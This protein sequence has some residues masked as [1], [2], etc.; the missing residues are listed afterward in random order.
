MLSPVP[1]NTT[2]QAVQKNAQKPRRTP[3]KRG[4][5]ENTV[6]A[7]ALPH[8]GIDEAGRGCLAG[9]VVAAAVLFPSGHD[10]ENNLPGLGDSKTL[11][12]NIRKSLANL[13]AEQAECYGIGLSWQEEID[14]VNIL[15]ATFRAMTRAVLA[16]S[17]RYQSIHGS[18]CAVP[19]LII[20]GNKVIPFAEWNACSSGISPSS[21]AWEQFFPCS[22]TVLPLRFPD[23]PRQ[24]AVV[25]GDALV[26]AIS[27]ASVLAKTVRDGLMERLD[28]FYPGYSLAVHKGYGTRDHL[29]AITM[30]GPCALHRKTF[31]GVRVEEIQAR[32]F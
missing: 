28:E 9:P 3:V 25:S 31:R 32:L 26:P 21:L 18:A 19:P 14:K 6:E 29:A 12:E 13:V 23:L 30:K 22:L 17:A 2:K 24:Y 15:N 4:L 16:L 1:K 7:L 8:I 27:A 20:D 5:P 11:R 10:F